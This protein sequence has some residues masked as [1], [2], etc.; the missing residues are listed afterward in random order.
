M[1]PHARHFAAK[2][3]SKAG[4]GWAPV[5][6]HACVCVLI[7]MYLCVCALYNALH[8]CSAQ[9]YLHMLTYTCS[10]QAY[11]HIYIHTYTHD[12]HGLLTYSAIL[13]AFASWATVCVRIKKYN[14][15]HVQIYVHANTEIHIHTY[16]PVHS[17]LENCPPMNSLRRALRHGCCWDLYVYMYVCMYFGVYMYVYLCMC[18]CM[19]A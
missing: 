9:A 12:T 8:T 10:A 14:Y 6:M 11:L 1:P 16:I 17:N 3:C 19:H 13:C 15:T 5:C 7:H 4:W 2:L 18:M